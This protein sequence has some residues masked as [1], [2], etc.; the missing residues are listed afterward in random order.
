MAALISC[1]PGPASTTHPAS[2]KKS[3]KTKTFFTTCSPPF[4]NRGIVKVRNSYRMSSRG[5]THDDE[6]I[7]SFDEAV[8]LFNTRDYYKCHDVLE[9]LWNN[10]QDPTRTLLHGILQCAVGFHHLFN[11][12]HKG[13]MM[14]LGEGLCKLRKMNFQNGPFH[15]FERDI[16]AVLEFIYQTQLEQAACQYLSLSLSFLPIFVI[17]F[18]HFKNPSR[19]RTSLCCNG[20]IR[21]VVPASRGLC[22]RRASLPP[23]N[24]PELER[25]HRFL[26][27]KVSPNSSST[28]EYK[29]TT[30]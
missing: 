28:A 6:E 30:A 15:Q 20:S 17:S 14:E 19:H 16:S 2:L 10:S 25:L 24:R 11:H 23:R 3:L 22:R 26:T 27:G 8:S 1:L 9:A 5:I 4:S 7:C 12:N 29:D 21:E 18:I 13:A